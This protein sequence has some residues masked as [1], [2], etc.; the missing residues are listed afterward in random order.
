MMVMR[1]LPIHLFLILCSLL[2]SVSASAQIDD[3]DIEQTD[4]TSTDW[5]GG[6]GG[7]GLNPQT[8]DDPV[9]SLTLSHT[10]LTMEGGER[11]RLVATVNA[12]AKNKAVRWTSADSH[13]ATVADNGTVTALTKGTTTITA[14]AAGNTSIKATC[15]VTVTSTYKGMLV[16]DVPFEFCYNAFDYDEATHS[17]PNHPQA[18]LSSYALQLT[19]S[20]PLFVN[21]ELLRIDERC[22]AYI[23]CWEKWSNESGAYFY[24]SGQ[25]CMTIVA[26]V[27]PRLNRDNASD[28][29]CNRGA[30]HNYMWRIGDGNTSFLHTGMAYDDERT[31]PLNSEQP[32]ILSVRVDG[33]NDYILLQNLT[34]GESRRADGVQWGGSDNVF[35]LFYNDGGEYWLG[36]FYWVYYSFNLL[37]DEQLACFSNKPLKGDVNGDGR[38]DIADVILV[39]K[40]IAD[41]VNKK[42]DVDGS[43]SVDFNDVLYIF[44]LL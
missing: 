32:Q 38:I 41:N 14:T 21:N 19:E 12:T 44:R 33:V 13:I 35:K 16:P 27:A 24:R 11:V 39:I 5:G 30:D 34:T 28:F 6:V 15:R 7:G 37:T 18:N 42:A 4:S 10:T 40:A 17:I 36:D 9:T 23:N 43:G 2:F 1:H 29:V 26:K 25:D 8:P 3:G 22:E 20:L 31:L